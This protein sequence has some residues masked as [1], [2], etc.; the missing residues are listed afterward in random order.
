MSGQ[1]EE[2]M[3]TPGPWEVQPT[4]PPGQLV[5]HSTTAK[6]PGKNQMRTV[7]WLIRMSDEDGAFIVKAVNAHETLLTT[8]LWLRDNYPGGATS[9]INEKIDAALRVAGAE[10]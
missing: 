5:I 1:S 10:R 9:L 8:L 7:G 6:G 2:K 4:E 3:A